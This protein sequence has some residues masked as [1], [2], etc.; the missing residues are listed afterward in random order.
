MASFSA[1]GPGTDLSVHAR[2]L[3]RAHDAAFSGLRP[4]VAPRPLVQRSWSRMVGLG[5]EPGR[6]RARDPL[7]R[8][9]VERRRRESPLS[10]VIAELTGLLGTVADASRFLIVVTDADGVILWREGAAPVQ[11]TADRLGFE[12]GATWTEDVVGTNAIGTAIAEAGPVQLFSAEHFEAAQHPWYCTAYPVHDPRTGE[13]LGIVDV[14]GPAL[15]LHPAI[16]ALVETGVR[17]SESLLWRHHEDRLA[18]LR[19]SS[20]HLLAASGS[21]GLVVDDHG[22]VAHHV[23]I[24]TRD[25]IAVPVEGNALVVP[26][27]GL[28]LPERIQDGWLVRSRAGSADV[29]ATL[30][31]TAAPVLRVG[32][33]EPWRTPLSPR[34]AQIVE[35]VAA[36]GSAGL[37]AADLSRLLHGDDQHVVT[38]RAEV[39]RLR[40]TI[41][42]LLA[43]QPYR[44]A[45]GVRIEVLRG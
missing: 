32:G 6:T 8:E 30:D 2:E 17:L 33:A 44:V 36:A 22:W 40:R 41:G 38:V 9:E 35:A 14:S 39:S 4:V 1:I 23:G 18:R 16:A 5:L 10:T 26:G 43:T 12:E 37:G 34:H 13:L 28:C 29:V 25:R 21:P 45:D 31:L 15:T 27:L 3:T 7:S 42:A 20:E 24:S 11:R 19:R